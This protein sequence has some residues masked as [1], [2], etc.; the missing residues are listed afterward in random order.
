MSLSK[1]STIIFDK[2]WHAVPALVLLQE[3]VLQLGHVHLGRALG[4]ARLALQAEV[5]HLVHGLAGEGVRP[6][7][8]GDDPAQGVGPAAG[9]MTIVA[10]RLEGGAHG[11]VHLAALAVAV[12]HLDGELEAA[13]AGKIERG[14]HGRA[15]VILPQP[16][17]LGGRG[18]VHDLARVHAA[19]GI[20]GT[21]H[22]PEGLV[23]LLPEE[24][25]DQPARLKNG[26]IVYRRQIMKFQLKIWYPLPVHNCQWIQ[27]GFLMT[28][29]SIG[30]DE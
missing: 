23:Q 13:V 17:M 24:P 28:P 30:T 10:R 6:Q 12:A 4:L 15:S 2:S 19:F 27:L 9:G 1:Y 5:H 25:L 29:Y 18:A 21:L 20:E 8:P 3:L 16:Q 11:A 26:G 22:R 7:P 14:L